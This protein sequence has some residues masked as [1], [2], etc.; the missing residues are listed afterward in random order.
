[1]KV[2]PRDDRTVVRKDLVRCRIDGMEVD[3]RRPRIDPAARTVDEGV[4]RRKD[5]IDLD[6]ETGLLL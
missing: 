2:L 6:D 3:V 4:H 5:L 1:M